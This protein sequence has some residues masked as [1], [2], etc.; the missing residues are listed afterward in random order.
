[1]LCGNPPADGT[2]RPRRVRR[3]WGM[4]ALLPP[5][6]PGPGEYKSFLGARPFGSQNPLFYTDPVR[7]PSAPPR[8]DQILGGSVP[9]RNAAA[10]AGSPGL[11]AER[12]LYAM[13]GA[14]VCTAPRGVC[15][16]GGRGVST[17]NSVYQYGPLKS[18][19]VLCSRST[20]RTERNRRP[21]PASWGRDSAFA[22]GLHGT[23]GLQGRA[24]YATF[25]G[26]HGTCAFYACFMQRNMHRTCVFYACIRIVMVI[27]PPEFSR[28]LANSRG[29][30]G[31][32]IRMSVGK[33]AGAGLP[34]RDGAH[35]GMLS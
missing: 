25:W 29:S 7:Q 30:G 28:I 15:G 12:P 11:G 26:K 8:I 22:N 27:I 35:F 5:N 13:G 19:P 1:M 18:P 9:P 31:L 4:P 3:A 2:E 21:G 20:P 32:V 10:G 14:S 33:N 6:L 24:G 23:R 16:E 17:W 34:A